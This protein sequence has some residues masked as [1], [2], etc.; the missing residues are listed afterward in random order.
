MQTTRQRYSPARQTRMVASRLTRWAGAKPDVTPSPAF[1][2]EVNVPEVPPVT[3]QQPEIPPDI[4]P[5]P[6]L[7]PDVPPD[8]EIPPG[9]PPDP[10]IPPEIPPAARSGRGPEGLACA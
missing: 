6:E 10:E 7:P 4:S 8:P 2:A 3:P 9:V 5:E 1:P